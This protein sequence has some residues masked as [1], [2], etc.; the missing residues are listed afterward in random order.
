MSKV[1]QIEH[2]LLSHHITRIRD[3]NSDTTVFRQ[4]MQVIGEILAFE[5]LRTLKT[6]SEAI[7]TP[8]TAYD[9]ETVSES[10]ALVPILRAGLA[11]VDPFTRFLPEATVLHLGMYRDEQTATP[12]WYYNKLDDDLSGM[13]AVI[14]DPMLATGGSLIAAIEE[15]KTHGV[16]EIRVS[17]VIAAPEGIQAVAESHPDVE[18]F[19][20][21]IDSH[22]NDSAF[23]VPGLGD[24]GDRYFGT[25]P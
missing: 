10:I 20:C 12:V 11:L 16:R 17:C 7:Q 21:E 18:I 5:T 25:T 14:L 13:T 8:L 23:I 9:G 3:V 6:R 15:L 22:L 4:S 2:A 19:V 24:A 1:S